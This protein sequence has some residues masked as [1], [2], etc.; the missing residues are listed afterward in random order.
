MERTITIGDTEV[1]F[2]GSARTA[3][4]YYDLF[5]KDLFDEIQVMSSGQITGKA[6]TVLERVAYVMARQADP[7]LE[8]TFDDWL[9]Q[10]ETIDMYSALP[11]ILAVWN[12]NT[13]TTVKSKKK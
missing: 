11:E 13:V 4:L 3:V 5:Q 1:R 12:V 9:D 2:R 6:V 7:D 10:F 8:L